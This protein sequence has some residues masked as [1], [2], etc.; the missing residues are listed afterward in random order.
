MGT[1]GVVDIETL[2]TK[3]I[4]LNKK[5]ISFY[6]SIATDIP[7]SV[8]LQY[9]YNKN[10]EKLALEGVSANIADIYNYY[11]SLKVISPQSRIE[12]NRPQILTE[13]SRDVFDYAAL[14]VGAK[15]YDFEI[16]NVKSPR[17]KDANKDGE[18][19]NADNNNQQNGN[20]DVA[21][22]A[23]LEPVDINK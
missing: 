11:K 3:I 9:Y 23:A 19:K 15:F 14:D 5:A 1:G 10:G 4:D 21:P 8:W 13:I 16:S 17:S 12:L 18:N 2:V 6:D 7:Q 22:A 20:P